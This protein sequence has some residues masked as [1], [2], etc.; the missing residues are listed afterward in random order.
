MKIIYTTIKCNIFYED[1]NQN[2]STGQ[3][4]FVL[5]SNFL[6]NLYNRNEMP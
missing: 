1:L 2:H 5:M 4:I 6:C 3:N